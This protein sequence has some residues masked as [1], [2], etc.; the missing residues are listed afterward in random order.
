ML[1]SD[2]LLAFAAPTAEP[3]TP[4]WRR[5]AILTDLAV[6]AAVT[7]AT[8]LF[9]WGDHMPSNRALLGCGLIGATLLVA[10]LP[11]A[12]AWDGAILGAGPAEFRRLANATIGATVTLALGGLTLLVASVRIWVFLLLPL[13]G[14]L[15]VLGRFVLRKRLHRAR[16]RGHCSV[17]VLAVGS[18]EAVED[19]IARTRRDPHFGW[20]VEGACTPTGSGTTED[21]ATIEDVAVVGDLDSVGAVAQQGGFRVVAVTQ[22]PGWGP[23]RLQRLAWELEST[24]ADLAVDP[25]LMEIAGPRLHIA[26]ID[27]LPLLRLSK[28]RFSGS[29]RVS[30]YIM[31]RV[32][33]ALILL[34]AFPLFLL[35][36]LAIKIDDAGPVF[37]RQERVGA[38]GSRFRMV[39]FRSMAVD[40]EARLEAL[41]KHNDFAGGTLFK[42]ARDPRITRV[43][44]TLRKYSIDELPQLLNVLTGTMSLVGPR[45]PLP[46]EVATYADDARRRLLVRPGMTG[47]WQVSGRSNLTWEESV[48]LDLRYVENWSMALDLTILWKTFGAV[49]N[50]RGAY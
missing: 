22:A 1:T 3:W 31:D 34:V 41:K 29:S 39:K 26:P 44:A 11:L 40:A 32:V 50:G 36:A 46:S 2:R 48:R 27:G 43:G 47:L 49:A 45:P 35:I 7:L 14:G 42:M 38:N 23:G 19:L 18:V 13:T 15:M 12:R 10:A 28:P 6:I 33:A 5:L 21:G 17:P 37:F 25:G 24:D 20:R 9:G 4:R 8:I 30:K 16:R